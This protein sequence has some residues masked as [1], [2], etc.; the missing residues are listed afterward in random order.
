MQIISNMENL[1]L[2][3]KNAVAIGK[4]D[5][6]HIGHRKLLQTIIHAKNQG[7]S[8]VVFTFEPSPEELFRGEL[9]P[10]LDTKEEKRRRFEEMGIDYLI[11]FPLTYE[12]AAIS[13]EQFMVDILTKRLHTELLV[14]GADLSF[15]D[16]G[17]GNATML[18]AYAEQQGF[19]YQVIDKVC[20]NGKE[21]S[22]TRIREAVS[23]G[24]MVLVSQLLGEPYGVS[25]TIV[26]GNHIGHSLDMPTVNIIPETC[27]LLPPNGVYATVSQ[28]LNDSY[29]GVTNIGYKPTV[30][31]E[32]VL[33]VETYLYD[34]NGDLYG[35]EIQTKLLHFMRPEQRFQSIE[36][37]KQQLNRDKENARKY[38]I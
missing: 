26:H 9:L 13:P 14:S 32:K 15:G 12:T 7:M 29:Y 37:L 4:F 23:T 27:K 16:K 10:V 20:V 6:I 34:F 5:G 19:Q 38:F 35:E 24:H 18:K 25:G 11:E 2:T 30:S 33:G 31:S 17:K 8:A 36:E 21:V 3:G 22:S 28:T 1:F